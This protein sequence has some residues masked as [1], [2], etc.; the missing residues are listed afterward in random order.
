MPKFGA[1][2]NVE[3]EKKMSLRVIMYLG[4]DE[5]L[6]IISSMMTKGKIPNNKTEI[7][8]EAYNRIGSKDFEFFKSKKENNPLAL[9]IFNKYFTDFGV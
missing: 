3:G 2:V 6:A 9:Q 8:T 1:V 5:F 7:M 4:R